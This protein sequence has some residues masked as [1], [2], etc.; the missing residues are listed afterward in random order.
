MLTKRNK[1]EPRLF[2]RSPDFDSGVTAEPVVAFGGRHEHVDPKLGLGLYG[3]YTPAGQ[4]KP[5]LTS[6]IVGV[7]GPPVMI[8]NAEAWLRR[9]AG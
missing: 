4:K 3:P 2:Q 9:C 8:A 5:P 7:V 1:E 6:I